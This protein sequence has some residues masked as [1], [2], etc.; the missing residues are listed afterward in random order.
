M[1]KADGRG[2]YDIVMLVAEI[3]RQFGYCHTVYT[4]C[5]VLDAPGH[6]DSRPHGGV[7]APGVDTGYA[8]NGG[9]HRKRDMIGSDG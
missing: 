8:G 3:E 6:P 5:D 9:D 4:S 1:V 2:A 7:G